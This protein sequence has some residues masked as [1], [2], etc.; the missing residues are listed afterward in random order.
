VADSPAASGLQFA[1]GTGTRK[2][3]LIVDDNVDG[4]NSL[5]SLLAFLGHDTAMEYDGQAAIDRAESFDA[6]VVLLDLGMPGLDGF[7]ICRRLRA[8]DLPHRPRIVAMTGWGR[9]EDRARTTAAGFDAHLVKPVDVATLA[10]LL[11]ESTSH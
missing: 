4:A 1:R 7:E 5:G 8:S 3:V 11:E 2:R 10:R 6:D 9:E